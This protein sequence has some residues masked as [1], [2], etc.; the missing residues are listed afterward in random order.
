[1][2]T[3]F[4]APESPRVVA[5][6]RIALGLAL[7]GDALGHWRYA[8]ELYST[9]GPAIPIFVRLNDEAPDATHPGESAPITQPAHVEPIVPVPVPEPRVAVAAQTFLIFSLFSVAV[10]WHTRT[11]LVTAFVLGLWLWPLDLPCTF[12]KHLVVGLHFLLLLA[13][14]RCGD[15][16]S[17]DA[18]SA[19]TRRDVC[20]TS[21]ICPRRL[22]QILICSVYAGAVVTKIKSTTFINGDLVLFSLLDDRWGGSRFGM[23]L[24]TFRH[25]PLVLSWM[26][27]VYEILF[28]ILVWVPRCRLP[29]LVVAFIVHGSMGWLL[30]LGPFTPIMLAALLS[31]LNEHDL[32][33]LGSRFAIRRT[34]FPARPYFCA[35]PW[36]S[37]VLSA[38]L[39]VAAAGVFVA[40][41][42][43]VQ[44]SLDWYGV[45]GRRTLAPFQEI[46][47]DEFTDMLAQRSPAYED[48]FHRID[49]GSRVGGNQVFG[50]PDRFQIGQRAYVV[51]QMPMPHPAVLLEGVLIAPDGQECARFKHKF[52]TGY[53]YAVNAFV[54]TAELSPGTY[55]VL[56]QA[57]GFIVAE[58]QFVLEA[59]P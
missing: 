55:R 12:G 50:A 56:I 40:A 33:W 45:F 9:Y 10:G 16:W 24:T 27:L 41:G 48:Y 29:M 44:S 4:F 11:S 18:W 54:L 57:D 7:L 22:M 5:L 25:I 30:S 8:V 39:H 1:M 37:I 20:R 23:W 47:E 26:T 51:S 19:R 28:P 52:G 15:C 42:D 46:P 13:F 34:G 6:V 43:A 59:E 53:P 2:K 35:R 58:R 38:G 14:S 3:F 32:A 31:F 21:S 49:M 17:V 36:K